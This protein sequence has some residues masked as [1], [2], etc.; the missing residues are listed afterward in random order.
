[1]SLKAQY[2]MNQLDMEIEKKLGRILFQEKL[3]FMKT[4]KLNC[5]QI[6]DKTM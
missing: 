6:F 3:F 2:C 1:M 4:Y 5:N